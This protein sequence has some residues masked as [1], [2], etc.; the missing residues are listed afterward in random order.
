MIPERKCVLVGIVVGSAFVS[1]NCDDFCH[2]TDIKK[3]FCIIA[4]ISF[5]RY[6]GREL[7]VFLA[8]CAIVA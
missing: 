5:Q 4:L 1:L 2:R 3:T 6:D 8:R 7:S